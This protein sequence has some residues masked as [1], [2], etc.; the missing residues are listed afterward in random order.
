ME[1]FSRSHTDPVSA[2]FKEFVDNRAV[3]EQAKGMLMLLYGLDDQ[4]AFEWLR[5]Q[6]Q[7]TNVKL[8]VLA[9]HLVSESRAHG[10][11]GCTSSNQVQ[12]EPASIPGGTDRNR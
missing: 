12:P 11:E 9:A 1:T 6:S 2:A 5:R 4:A 8:R 10:P 3:I 7:H